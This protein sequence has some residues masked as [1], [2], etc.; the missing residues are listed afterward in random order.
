[1]SLPALEAV[2][3]LGRAA[4]RAA[5]G[6]T[7]A[8]WV[9]KTY[10]HYLIISDLQMPYHNPQALDFCRRV[11]FDYS[12]PTENV[13]CV[14]DEFDFYWLSRFDKSPDAEHSP[15]GE[16]EAAKTEV[17]R[18]AAVFPF[19]RICESNHVYGRL[20]GA[21]SRAGLAS[22]WIRSTREVF[23]LPE[24]WVYSQFWKVEASKMPFRVEHGHMRPGGHSGL[25]NRPTNRGISTA[26][27]HEHAEPATI[28]VDTAGGQK[29]W[30]MR[31]GSLLT[32]CRP[33][34]QRRGCVTSCR[35][36]RRRAG[37]RANPADREDLMRSKVAGAP[38]P[39]EPV[40]DPRC[41]GCKHKDAKLDLAV[42]AFWEI[43]KEIKDAS[44]GMVA[45]IREIVDRHLGPD[46][47]AR[48]KK[49]CP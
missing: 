16:L 41:V 28:H 45:R 19:M 31:T 9:R 15:L 8:P 24:T 2:A 12:I 5:A 27:G 20:K 22:P 26:W 21:A 29:V 38:P 7:K 1:M 36:C 30:G 4:G 10:D 17:Q 42:G 25:R 33:E 18:W 43:R 44:G 48:P 3:D 14:G 11:K 32:C 49:P 13:L 23:G 6:D 35:I 46:P 40:I 47:A 34:L 37:R 39:E